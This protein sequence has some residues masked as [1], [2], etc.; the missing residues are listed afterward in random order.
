MR[1]P[2]E[3]TEAKVALLCSWAELARGGFCP[4]V[5]AG[6]EYVQ[7]DSSATIIKKRMACRIRASLRECFFHCR[8]ALAAGARSWMASLPAMGL[9]FTFTCTV[10]RAKLWLVAMQ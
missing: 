6:S 7:A 3:M 4:A 1:L 10:G 8:L 5:C 2:T 9:T